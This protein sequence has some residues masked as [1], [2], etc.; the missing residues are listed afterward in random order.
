MSG[1]TDRKSI[2]KAKLRV[3]VGNSEVKAHRAIDMKEV[4]SSF[5]D[6]TDELRVASLLLQ[7]LYS[8][9]F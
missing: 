9:L 7:L 6:D 8:L 2:T 4:T 1:N 5:Y 3:H